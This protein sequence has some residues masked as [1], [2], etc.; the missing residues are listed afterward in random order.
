MSE[1]VCPSA[2]RQAVLS[3]EPD[4]G[5]RDPDLVNQKNDNP[6][7]IR[8]DDSRYRLKVRAFKRIFNKNQT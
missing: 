8:A 7:I 6:G 3:A 5:C 4:A 1:N 2:D